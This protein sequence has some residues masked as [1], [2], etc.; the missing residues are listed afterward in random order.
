MP[1][2]S[3]G[4]KTKQPLKKPSAPV[5]RKKPTA[6]SKQKS[7]SSAMPEKKNKAAPSHNNRP[8]SDPSSVMNQIIP[9]ILGLIAFIIG[10]CIF[11]DTLMGILG[12]AIR[13]ILFGLYSGGAFAVPFLILNTAFFWKKDIVNHTI[14]YKI[15]FSFICLTF[16]SVL[17]YISNMTGETINLKVFWNDGLLNSGGGAI[18]GTVG[19]LLYKLVGKA[20]T[21]L[22]S[23]SMLII[24]GIFLFGLTPH[25]IRVW[26]A[27]Q[28]HEAKQR[29]SETA[30]S[31]PQKQIKKP[32]PEPVSEQQ[33]DDRRILYTDNKTANGKHRNILN[34][35]TSIDDTPENT[36][37]SVKNAD[38]FAIDPQIYDSVVNKQNS[39]AGD[40]NSPDNPD[41][42]PAAETDK[43]KA[44][45]VHRTEGKQR[46]V[47]K[48]IEGTDYSEIFSEDKEEGILSEELLRR[49][50]GNPV[51]EGEL[52]DENDALIRA[53][54]ELTIKRA[55]AV[56]DKL[57]VA[58]QDNIHEPEYIYP[59][60]ALLTQGTP[61]AN[62]DI[63]EELQTT[64][65]RLVDTLASFKVRTK[66]VNVSRGPTITRYEL[67]PDEGIRVRQIVNLV[68]D[69][70]LNLATTGVRIE[71]PIPGKQAVGIEVPNRIVATVYLRELIDNQKFTALTSRISV[72]LGDDV[73][74]E[75]VYIDISK[76]PHLLIAGATGMGKSVCI[77]S[78][79]VSLLYK[80]TPDE[81]KLILVDPK[82]VEL[83]IY[84]GLPHL[85]VPV[86][87]DPK[88]AAGA[89]QWAVTEMER[90]F[91]LIE[92][93]GM[94]DLRGYNNITK[95]DSEKE[96]LPQIV[97]IIDELAD[98][99][100]TAPDDVEESICRLAQKARAAGMH[101]I[102]GTQRPSVDVITGLI[103]ANIPSRIAFTVASQ[104]DSRTI[105]DI[106]GA[107][108]LIGRGDMLY[109]P[110]GS[111][112]PIRVQGAYVSENEIEA[113]LTFIKSHYGT[114]EYNADVISSIEREAARCGQSKK[115][116]AAALGDENDD[117]A[118]PMLKPA[119]E[120]AVESGKIST[121]LIQRRL[122]L[123]Y[124]R[125]AKL[126]DR[127]EQMGVVSP[128][129]GQRPRS[130]LIS[131]QQFMEMVLNKDDIQ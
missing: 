121:S 63:S 9:F 86:V 23:V 130:V 104:V 29:R 127:M 79:I 94:R 125:A 122:Q 93:V 26:I 43:L 72:S 18:G 114:G 47:R 71:A 19:W 51:P 116:A 30:V 55:P 42:K 34:E 64:A 124:G 61:P 35:D 39:Q 95:D 53:E 65:K 41:K 75:P 56:E 46:P 10:I 32:V 27:Y 77:N 92:E 1:A 112:K 73:A 48:M 45:P 96:F 52:Y 40:D 13:L 82:K 36:T 107:E 108:K 58:V 62:V 103:K 14:K 70:S 89:L 49:L 67:A 21:V 28:I 3:T 50:T 69:I 16:I 111:P 6:A 120:L 38:E 90:R 128:P 57:P 87:S 68:D 5:P 101:L 129:D 100:M 106:A 25:G 17:I 105:I 80:A 102:I 4:G 2:K 33:P 84:N 60:V 12:S 74:G 117:G 115:G 91:T 20:G 119:I 123:G 8:E 66:I 54:A 83:N 97:I 98:L 59:P 24:F 15:A 31:N 88:K 85:L 110:V 118:D 44:E 81:V 22:V 11:S 126:I 76:M 7:V 109:A 37:Q 78:M 99:M 113:I 131:K